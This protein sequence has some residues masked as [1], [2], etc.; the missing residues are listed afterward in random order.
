MHDRIPQKTDQT[1]EVIVEMN[2][3]RGVRT[4][5]RGRLDDDGFLFITGRFKEEYKLANGKI[6]SSGHH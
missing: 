5:D 1:K 6:Y 2:G 4:G 3:M